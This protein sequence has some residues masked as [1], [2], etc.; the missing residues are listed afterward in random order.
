MAQIV[1]IARIA[2]GWH[3][4]IV[5]GQRR[6]FKN[7]IVAV[8]ARSSLDVSNCIS[9]L[10]SYLRYRRAFEQLTLPEGTDGPK[11]VGGLTRGP[12]DSSA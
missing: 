1:R 5:G 7:H 12:D 4:S 2:P 6:A 8:L 3:P 10:H 11:P 9:G